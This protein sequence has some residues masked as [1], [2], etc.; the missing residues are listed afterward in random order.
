MGNKIN[1]EQIVKLIAGKDK[2]QSAFRVVS[3]NDVWDSIMEKRKLWQEE[4][5][6]GTV[7]FDE[8]YKAIT[9]YFDE[10]SDKER[11]H[12]YLDRIKTPEDQMRWLNH[13]R[14]K[15]W[16]TCAVMNDFF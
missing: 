5:R 6:V 12:V 16:F 15:R 8:D 1:F 7:G 10:Q 11:Y 4:R 13:L 9:F 2:P 14:Q 3:V